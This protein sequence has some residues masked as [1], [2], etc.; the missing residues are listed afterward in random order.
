MFCCPHFPIWLLWTVNTKLLKIYYRCFPKYL[1]H[2]PVP[3]C[4]M[5]Q[6]SQI[7]KYAISFSVGSPLCYSSALSCATKPIKSAILVCSPAYL[8]TFFQYGAIFHIFNATAVSS[9][10]IIHSKNTTLFSWSDMRKEA[11]LIKAASRNGKSTSNLW[12]IS[13]LV[14]FV[15]WCICHTL[16][17]GASK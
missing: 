9:R 7:S 11:F 15:V 8:L 6:W 14:K 10:H 12:A 4:F 3:F 17:S 13:F 5:H 16:H 1:S 2:I